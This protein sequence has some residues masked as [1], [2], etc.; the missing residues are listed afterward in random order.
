LFIIKIH[1]GFKS[2]VSQRLSQISAS[3][4]N[5]EEYWFVKPQWYDK[6]SGDRQ[7]VRELLPTDE[8]G[9]P[10]GDRNGTIAC[11]F[12]K[13]RKKKLFDFQK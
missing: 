1:L 2:G 6:S 10:L 5:I 13:T 7:T 9:N 3:D 4:P 12:H 11:S 8:H